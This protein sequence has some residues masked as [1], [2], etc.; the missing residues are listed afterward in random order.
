MAARRE[1]GLCAGRSGRGAAAYDRHGMVRFYEG[2]GDARAG[3]RQG[4]LAD[5]ERHPSGSRIA[6]AHRRVD[7]RA[8]NEAI[9]SARQERGELPRG[10]E[11]GERRFQ[12]ND[13][14]RVFAPGDRVVFLEN[15][16]DLQ[17]KNG[18]LGTVRE[19]GEG[20]LVAQLDGKGRDGR[21]R[22]ISVPMGAIAPLITA[23]RRRSTRRKVPRSTRPS[24]SLQ[25]PWIVTAY[26]AMTRH[27]QG[28]ELHAST[29][30]SATAWRV[31]RNRCHAT[32]PRKPR[33]TTRSA[34]LPSGEASVCLKR[35]DAWSPRP[36]RRS[37]C[38]ACLHRAHVAHGDRREGKGEKGESNASGDPESGRG[39]Q[40]NPAARPVWVRF[41]PL[42]S[43]QHGEDDA[44][45]GSQGHGRRVRIWRL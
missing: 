24:C 23:T 4:Y 30:S 26:V 19:V 10:E 1:P 20:R 12:T 39:C 35:S 6:L 44:P 21:D 33:S 42:E 22:I 29:K 2:Q 11:A 25:K 13:G 27:R 15:N 45:A 14:E 9:R 31:F 34:I 7:V 5:A 18:M 3:H 32:A 8:L 37:G 36:L 38:Q 16:R 17:V 40:G 41:G 28:V 43:H